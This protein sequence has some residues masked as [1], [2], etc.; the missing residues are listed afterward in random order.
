MA[1]KYTILID[2]EPLDLWVSKDNEVKKAKFMGKNA[3]IALNIGTLKKIK[4]HP[5]RIINAANFQDNEHFTKA[6]SSMMDSHLKLAIA[7]NDKKV[8][9]RFAQSDLV[10]ESQKQDF[11]SAINKP[12][13]L[14]GLLVKAVNNTNSIFQGLAKKV[15]RFFQKT[16]ELMTYQK[17][18]KHL[19][20]YQASLFAQA[21]PYGSTALD[22][23]KNIAPKLA[24]MAQNFIKNE[25]LTFLRENSYEDMLKEE[26][27][28]KSASREGFSPSDA[29][30]SLY[31][32]FERMEHRQQTEKTVEAYNIAGDKI[33][34]LE[35][36]LRKYEIKEG[37]K[38]ETLEDFKMISKDISSVDKIDLLVENKEYISLS[39]VE[40]QKVEDKLLTE[41]TPIKER[42]SELKQLH[43]VLSQIKPKEV[44]KEVVFERNATLNFYTEKDKI[45]SKWTELQKVNRENQA[46]NRD[47]MN[48]SAVRFGGV[49]TNALNNWSE[50]A[51]KRGVDE[52]I[53]NKF[54]DATLRN[55]D[56]LVKA[57]IFKEPVDG[58]YKFIDQFA[59]ETL[60]K[61]LDKT[62]EQI[63]QANLGIKTEIEINP[64]SELS[65]RVEQLSSKNSFENMLTGGEIDSQKLHEYA[66]QLQALATQLH[67]QETKN[68]VTKED[69]REIDNST[70]QS[71]GSENVR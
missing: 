5:T 31:Q 53:V 18:D 23:E 40:K 65:E 14:R 34:D 29:R 11:V 20:S 36:Q 10:P 50:S 7:K 38:N 68:I 27:F 25:K 22:M 8:L 19:E 71:K 6:V 35:N 2:N 21:P 56:E 9:S 51:I 67:T 66:T 45:A 30:I 43:S 28:M 46:Q 41:P 32:Q 70:E 37:S 1:K 59:K 42:A 4:D 16:N 15:D 52:K 33:K 60:Y 69:L 48:I 13:G 49:S 64:K 17:A 63:K 58:S 55:A 54:K 12:R 57:G 62:N 39:D 47:F 44:E 61:N 3:D 24:D 26:R